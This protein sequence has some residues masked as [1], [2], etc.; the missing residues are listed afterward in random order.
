[1]RTLKLS[2]AWLAAGLLLGNEAVGQAFRSGSNGSY[3]AINTG[4]STVTLDVPADGIFH[5]TTIEV[6]SGGVLRF[7]RNALNTPVHLLATGDVTVTGTID[8]SGARGTALTPGLGGPGGFDGGSPGSVGFA[9]GDGHGPGGGKGGTAVDGPDE[10]GGGGFGAVTADSPAAKR[11]GV[12]GSPLLIPMVGGSGGGGAAG[13]TGW[14][15][16]GGGG[17]I[18]I[19]SDSQI[20]VTGVINANGGQGLGAVVLN[21]GSGGAIRLVAPRISGNGAQRALGDGG[22]GNRG[23]GRIRIDALDRSAL[24]MS[25]LPAEG[26]S[27]GGLMLVFPDPFPRLDIVEAA[28][29]PVPQDTPTQVLLPGGSPATQTI[30]VRARDF[31]QVVPIRV[32]LTPDSGPSSTFDSQIDNSGVNPVE[33]T[34]DVTFP[35]NVLTRVSVFTR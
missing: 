30:R 19:A 7:R 28:G 24:S 18:L 4:G 34:V 32:V 22:R 31:G 33:A 23:D 17:A 14:G 15:G 29:R 27:V 6:G 20:T 25:L 21:T 11:G 5:C 9:A 1:M 35:A 3:G 26:S 16:G 12:Y 13:A 8:V 10:A 2:L